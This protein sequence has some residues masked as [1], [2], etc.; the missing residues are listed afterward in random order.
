MKYK[1]GYTQKTLESS[2]QTSSGATAWLSL[3][4]GSS[5]FSEL[6]TSNYIRCL[7][8]DPG[9]GQRWPNNRTVF[10][11]LLTILQQNRQIKK[12]ELCPDVHK[13]LARGLHSVSSS[14][15]FRLFNYSKSHFY[16]PLLVKHHLENPIQSFLF[17]FPCRCSDSFPVN[18]GHTCK[19]WIR[20]LNI[21]KRVLVIFFLILLNSIFMPRRLRCH[22]FQGCNSS[23]HLQVQCT[24]LPL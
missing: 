15:F 8:R 17:H 24:L 13:H 16:C 7:C 14:F 12:V 21:F 10:Q 18:S 2:S 23:M 20:T 1:T 4:D 9:A 3:A 22:T 6:H 19:H 11:C 5:P